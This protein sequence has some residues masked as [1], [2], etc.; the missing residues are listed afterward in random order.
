[1]QDLTPQVTKALRGGGD[2]V[3]LDDELEHFA[4]ARAQQLQRIAGPVVSL[5]L[6]HRVKHVLFVA[7]EKKGQV[8]Q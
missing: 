3:G 8:F 6:F 7:L 1:M 4:L 5:K 2:V